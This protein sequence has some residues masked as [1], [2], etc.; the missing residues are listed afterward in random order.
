MQYP[1][2][3]QTYPE[4]NQVFRSNFNLKAKQEIDQAE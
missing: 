1:W 4:S 3:K 2:E